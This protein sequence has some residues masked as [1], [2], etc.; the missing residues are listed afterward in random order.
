MHM[1]TLMH[2]GERELIKKVAPA[3]HL[4]PAR[5]LTNKLTS[6][7]TCVECCLFYQGIHVEDTLLP[8]LHVLFRKYF[9]L[10]MAWGHLSLTSLLRPCVFQCVPFL[11]TRA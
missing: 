3:S 2:K 5:F 6:Q 4:F 11:G 9:S 1:P 8:V 7:Q 10:V